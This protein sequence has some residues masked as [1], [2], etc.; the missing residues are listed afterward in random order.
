MKYEQL[1]STISVSD[2]YVTHLSQLEVGIEEVSYRL[3]T[4]DYSNRYRYRAGPN[5]SIHGPLVVT[6][7]LQL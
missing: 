2:S 5:L 6:T 7:H 1:G 4:P 3:K